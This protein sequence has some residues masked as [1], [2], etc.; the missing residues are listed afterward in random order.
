MQAYPNEGT[1]ILALQMQTLLALSKLRL[2]KTGFTPSVSSVLADFVANEADYT[3]Y[4]AGGAVLTAWL[5]PVNR[6]SGGTAIGSPTVQF[7]A[8]SPFTL[9][10]VVGGWF[11]VAAAGTS[12]VAFGTFDSPIPIGALGQGFPMNLTLAFPNGM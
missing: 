7:Q 9:A 3:G 8:A 5:N 6:A 2:F 12:V 11:L 10:N 1:R 4:T